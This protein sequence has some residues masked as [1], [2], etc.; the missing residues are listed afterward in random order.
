MTAR[1]PV[2]VICQGKYVLKDNIRVREV[3]GTELNLCYV[4][5]D[6]DSRK[7]LSQNSPTVTYPGIS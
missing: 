1:V 5:L 4:V 6:N 3:I 7:R 2:E